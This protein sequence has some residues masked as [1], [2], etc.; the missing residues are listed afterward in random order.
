[1]RL[2]KGRPKGEVMANTGKKKQAPKSSTNEEEN[3]EQAEIAPK[4]SK[5]KR[6]PKLIE[7]VDDQQES[8]TAPSEGKKSRKK[9]ELQ[10]S[11]NNREEDA[12]AEDVPKASKK[13]KV[14]KPIVIKGDD[15]DSQME[16]KSTK[17]PHVSSKERT[18]VQP[19][20]MITSSTRKRSGFCKPFVEGVARKEH[21][22]P[23]CARLDD[24]HTCKKLGGGKQGKVYRCYDQNQ[25]PVV[26]KHSTRKR[27]NMARNEVLIACQ[28]GLLRDF[29]I[30][31]TFIDIYDYC[32][33]D[34]SDQHPDAFRNSS[35]PISTLGGFSVMEIVATDPWG[36]HNGFDTY[37]LFELM[38]SII[39]AHVTVEANVRD[40]QGKHL[41]WSYEAVHRRY[42]VGNASIVLPPGRRL[43]IFDLATF[44][45]HHVA[46]DAGAK[47]I[48]QASKYLHIFGHK[49]YPTEPA[50]QLYDW[51]K[52]NLVGLEPLQALET[53]IQ[54]I[55]DSGNE[56][57]E[58]PPPGVEIK[59]YA[60][61]RDTSNIKAVYPFVNSP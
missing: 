48:L 1:M 2:K 50:W 53:V 3:Q 22:E 5:K 6:L 41:G 31:D 12:E 46:K 30:S 20:E 45:M 37:A 40:L 42:T 57:V 9:K 21:T 23:T 32:W 17:K 54:Q 34:S 14:P 33:C 58:P 39:A 28:M 25:V 55:K 18:L 13:K 44:K 10:T 36:T 35:H 49:G 43:R 16:G 38:Y 26:V 19:K 8:N 51:T 24:Y 59:D 27:D 61:P 15:T 7:E 4:V 52:V 60:L 47:E 56:E 11:T 29:N